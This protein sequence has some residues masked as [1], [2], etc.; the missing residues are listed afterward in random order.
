MRIRRAAP[1]LF[2]VTAGLFALALMVAGG[3]ALRSSAAGPTTVGI[4]FNTADNTALTAGAITTCHEV[5]SGGSYVFDVY[6]QNVPGD[7]DPTT[8]DGMVAGQYTLN[9][10]S[11]NT[12]TARTA[13]GGLI[14]QGTGIGSPGGAAI[15]NT[16]S[17]PI[18]N[19]TGS[20]NITASNDSSIGVS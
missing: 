10:V 1:A 17:S 8:P 18:N 4:D 3:S 12:E 5:A 19:S 9:S 20:D 14:D 11:G 15:D 16:S 6:V 7:T 13:T 2:L